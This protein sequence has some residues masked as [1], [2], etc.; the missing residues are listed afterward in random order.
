MASPDYYQVLGISRKAT[1][2]EIRRA[3]RAL[4]RKFH[5]DF[6]P[7]DGA[8]L[9]KFR[10]IREGYKV[11]SSSRRRKAYDYYGPDFCLRIPTKSVEETGP[12][13]SPVP[14]CRSDSFR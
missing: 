10:E 4:A 14:R 9:Q 7:G 11:L 5:P 13:S 2:R 3:Y 1:A 12:P 6:N 8:A